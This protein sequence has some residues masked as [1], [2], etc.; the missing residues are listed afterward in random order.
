MKTGVT[1]YLKHFIVSIFVLFTALVIFGLSIGAS[2]SFE[3]DKRAYKMAG[4]GPHIFYTDSGLE[5]CTIRGSRDDGFYID[6]TFQDFNGPIETEAYFALEDL[7]FGLTINPEI[8]IPTST[9][10]D[11]QKILAISDIESN[12]KTFRDFLVS[13]NVIDSELN[14][15][16][17]KNH[18]VLVGD[19][20]DR[21]YSVTQ[22]LWFIYKLE[23]DA[24]K[25][26]GNVHF[27]LGNHEIKNLQANFYSAERK[28]FHIAAMLGR[29]QHE[30][31]GR[32]SFIGRWLAS[33]NTM[34][35][36]NGNIFVHGG[37]HPDIADFDLSL[38]EINQIV[39]DNYYT[40]FFTKKE[41]SNEQ[42]L[43]S[44]NTGPSWYRGYFKDDLT[45]DEVEAGL[46]KFGAKTVVVGHTIHSKVK[47]FFEGRVFAID[48][49][50]PADYNATFPIRSS[51]GLL[52]DGDNYY[53]VLDDGE[54]VLL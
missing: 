33:K 35:M 28:Y 44:T 43:V 24:I 30:L 34:E 49:K 10:N 20:V 36:I 17:G 3:T 23:Q 29:Q 39:R 8:S 45:Q 46:N 18:L 54:K 22:V 6:Q 15:T 50:H 11:T 25:Q 13:N 9:Y 12:F 7:S 5:I 51:E 42:F 53:R 52:I 40:P 32:N 16:F 27:I 48:V 19:F 38:K 4:E 31:Y 37:I 14:W 1:T 41:K 26:G 47:K 21:G 2:A